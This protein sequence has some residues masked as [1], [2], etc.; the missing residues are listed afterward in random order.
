MAA[1]HRDAVVEFHLASGLFTRPER[2]PAKPVQRKVARR[3]FSQRS[4]WGAFSMG[5]FPRRTTTASEPGSTRIRWVSYPWHA[6]TPASGSQIH[7]WAPQT[8]PSSSAA[9]G[10]RA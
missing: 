1:N 4:T 7:Q 3:S 6:K 9:R 10:V 8:F 5:V 2:A